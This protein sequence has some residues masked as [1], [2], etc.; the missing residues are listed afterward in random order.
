MLR[1]GFAALLD[2][3]LHGRQCSMGGNVAVYVVQY[4]FE[5][6]E[7]PVFVGVRKSS[8]PYGS[9][10][11]LLTPPTIEIVGLPG[12]HFVNTMPLRP[13][14]KILDC[15]EKSGEAVL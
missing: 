4:I 9:R 8:L 14:G 6:R 5:G 11:F 12:L 3:T 15:Q 2:R 13:L 10:K 1:S 7:G